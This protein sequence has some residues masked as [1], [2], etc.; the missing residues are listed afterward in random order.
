[1]HECLERILRG[2]PPEFPNKEIE[3]FARG[4]EVPL[5]EFDS[6]LWSE[7][8]LRNG[9][10][11]CWSTDNADDPHRLARVWSNTYGFA[12]TPDGVGV[13]RGKNVLI[14]YK[15]SKIP[16]FQPQ[17]GERVGWSDGLGFK[18]YKKTVR[19][20]CLYA[21]ALQETLGVIV[22]EIEIIVGLRGDQP[23][24]HLKVRQDEIEQERRTAIRLCQ[25]FWS[26]YE[27]ELEDSRAETQKTQ[28]TTAA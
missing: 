9:W 23:A 3:D 6:W 12:G 24:Q 19:Q 14:D 5:R 16:Y 1:V 20:L 7:R 26:L 13:R 11:H 22:D 18:K 15:T 10:E 25:E 21:I 8:P 27:L 28:L 17:P 2:L 4:M